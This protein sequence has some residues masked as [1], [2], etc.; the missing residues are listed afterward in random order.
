[1]LMIE[2]VISRFEEAAKRNEALA[3]A[4]MAREANLKYA[5]ENRQ[6]ADWLKELVEFRKECYLTDEEIANAIGSTTVYSAYYWFQF[7]QELKVLGYAVVK[8]R[9]KTNEQND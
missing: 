7:I 1:M 3:G 4:G 2:D 8:R 9:T 6:M 5:E